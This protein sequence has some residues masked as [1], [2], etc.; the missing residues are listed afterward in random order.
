MPSIGAPKV[1]FLTRRPVLVKP[2]A[3]SNLDMSF[4]IWQSR[5]SENGKFPKGIDRMNLTK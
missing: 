5:D 2:I 1:A 4:K 3:K